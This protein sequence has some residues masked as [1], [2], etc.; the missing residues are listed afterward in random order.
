MS[1]MSEE[2]KQHIEGLLTHY[3]RQAA[4]YDHDKQGWEDQNKAVQKEKEKLRR[5]KE[6]SQQ[7]EPELGESSGEGATKSTLKVKSS[8]GKDIV[9][10]KIETDEQSQ[11]TSHGWD[12]KQRMNQ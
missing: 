11:M 12:K 7:V 2:E 3:G 9:L 10:V 5:M 4:E 6:S 8:K 1:K